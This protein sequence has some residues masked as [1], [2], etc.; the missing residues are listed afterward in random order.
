MADSTKNL[1]VEL[2]SQIASYCSRS[3]LYSLALTK[4][5]FQ[6]EAERMLYSCILFYAG[7]SSS[8]K[9]FETLN[10]NSHKARLVRFLQVETSEEFDHPA[11]PL[12][13]IALVSTLPKL[14]SLADFRM[15]ISPFTEEL[16]EDISTILKARYFTLHT[17]MCD[18]SMDLLNIVKCQKSL[19]LVGIYHEDGQPFIE[20]RI[21]QLLQYLASVPNG[22]FLFTVGCDSYIPALHIMGLFP[23]CLRSRS[24]WRHD[25][26]LHIS[27]QVITSALDRDMGRHMTLACDEIRHLCLF[28]E[29]FDN[30]HVD[31][32]LAKVISDVAQ[33]FPS[34]NGINLLARLPSRLVSTCNIL[35][36]IN[37]F[38]NKVRLLKGSK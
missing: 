29:S 21:L 5:A 6:S 12:A 22:P 13:V 9:V 19:K 25:S 34:V 11:D 30:L 23:G 4:K 33:H 2:K 15:R 32:F 7:S 8:I 16:A 20:D 18:P 26:D 28:F 14:T 38:T 37:K 10:Y 17:L 24:T 31:D 27:W 3:T 1:P 36:P 35:P